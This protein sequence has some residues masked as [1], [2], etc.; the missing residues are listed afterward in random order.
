MAST[1]VEI[2]AETVKQAIRLA[3]ASVN[4]AAITDYFDVRQHYLQLRQRGKR[5]SW[6]V[7]A[8][9]RSQLIGSAILER[10]V[11][12]GD[13]LT[14]TQ[15]R[16]KSATVYAG[17][18]PPEPK[19]TEAKAD[20]WTWAD[21]DREYQA[22]L[23]VQ[24]WVS[25]SKT[26]PPN[27]GTQ[28][29]VRLA[30]AKP[31]IVA[32]GPK[33]LTE[34]KPRDIILAIEEVHLASGHRQC[35]K[36]LTYIKSALSWAL[37]DRMIA[38]GIEDMLPWWAALKP[39]KPSSPEMTAMKERSDRL[40]QAKTD[41]TVDHLGELLAIHEAFCAGKSGNEKISPGIRWGLWWLLFT[42]NRRLSTTVLE[43]TRLRQA[44][45]FGEPGWGRA[46]W[47]LESMK[48][49]AE[50][51]LPIP[52]VALHVANS[53]MADWKSLVTKSTSQYEETQWVFASTRRI[54]RDPDNRDVAVYPNSL[55]HHL[56]NLRGEKGVDAKNLIEHLP[57]F[58]LHLVRSVTANYLE[59]RADV[60]PAAASL[61]LA[62]T[63]P[64]GEKDKAAPTT[65]KF[66]LTGQRMDMKLIAMKAWSEALMRAYYK[67]GGVYPQP[68][69]ERHPAAQA[70]E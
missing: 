34:L 7:R 52:P 64:G 68:S 49:K 22:S 39:P 20:A 10:G 35:A 3:A 62:H 53:S 26:K 43:R 44:D 63:L 5:V 67:A 41:F 9:G 14:I 12:T 50:F 61:M 25:G 1:R 21:L 15:A 17:I 58:W 51:W 47:P 4:S 18:E 56:R 45:P 29:D 11:T 28:D 36:S 60:P 46:E 6:F 31:S 16:D 38:A 69:E 70:A 40:L 42:A 55:N 2:N 24:R 32:L 27:K 57:P 19:P 33:L 66:Y 54:G 30:L 13:F 8:R 65:K 48:A 37:S 59:T 23:T